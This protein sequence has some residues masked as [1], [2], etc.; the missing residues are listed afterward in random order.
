MPDHFVPQLLLKNFAISGKP[1]KIYAYR[2]NENISNPLSIRKVAARKNF[3]TLKSDK[4]GADK[5][6]IEKSFSLHETGAAP[7]IKHFLTSDN[8]SLVDNDREI[9]SF[10]IAGLVV[11]SPW[12]RNKL[13][14][15]TRADYNDHMRSATSN[16]QVFKEHCE[17]A[18]IEISDPEELERMRIDLQD[19]E[20]H[21]KLKP[22]NAETGDYLKLWPFMFVEDLAETISAKKRNILESDSSRVFVISDNPV[23]LAPPKPRTDFF[24]LS[25]APHRSGTGVLYTF[26]STSL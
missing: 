2:R 15:T 14:N 10:F 7:I 6:R 21:T 5:R 8:A 25:S 4:V 17:R 24:T 9:L 3:Y 20:K 19:L 22:A 18:G 12:F 16:K 26:S 11:R 13:W 1:G 23:V